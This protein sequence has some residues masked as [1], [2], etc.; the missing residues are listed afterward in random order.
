MDDS[1]FPE[2]LERKERLSG[3]VQEFRCRLLE[4]GARAAAVLFV[5][6]RAYQVADLAL[7]EGTVTFGH[8]WA[9][10]AYNAYHWLSPEGTT[11]GYYFNLSDRTQISPTELRWRDLAVDVLLRPDGRL[12]VLDEHELPA[13]LDADLRARIQT[14]RAQVVAAAPALG[15]ELEARADALWTRVFGRPRA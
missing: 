12:D 9:D 8:F 15:S 2:I 5:S 14:A 13:D 4:G 10:R 6:D 11:L 7:P 3:R 1:R